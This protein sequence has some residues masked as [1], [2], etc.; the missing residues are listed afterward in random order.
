MKHVEHVI[1]ADEV[2]LKKTGK[3]FSWNHGMIANTHRYAR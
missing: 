1:S 2:R 3:K